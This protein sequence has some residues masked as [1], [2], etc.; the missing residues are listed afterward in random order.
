MRFALASSWHSRLHL[1]LV[2]LARERQDRASSRRIFKVDRNSK[3]LRH[4]ATK[5]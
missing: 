5:Q 3:F 4:E 2:R 1:Y